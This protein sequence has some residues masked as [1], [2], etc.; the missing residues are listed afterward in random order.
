[1]RYVVF[2][3]GAIGGAIGGRLFESGQPVVL[4]ARGEHQQ[5][6]TERGLELRDPDSTALLK[7]PTVG[8]IAEAE[9]RAGDVVI[10]AVKSQHTGA[11]LDE[12]AASAPQSITLVC[13]QNGVANERAGLRLFSRVYGMRVILAA[14]H[15]EPGVVE[16]STAPVAGIL[17]V[18]RYPGG[19]DETATKL[20][21]DLCVA[22]FDAEAVQDVM[23]HKY[24][25]LLTNLGNAIEAACGADR[26]DDPVAKSLEEEA[27][28]EARRC[29]E[30]AGIT[31]ADAAVE[32]DQRRRRGPP[33]PVLGVTRRGGSS[34]QSLAR[35]TGDIEADWLN[36]E[37]VL[38]GRL[39]GIETPVNARLQHVANTMARSRSVP[40]SVPLSE[41]LA[42]GPRSRS[43]L[44]SR[45]MPGLGAGT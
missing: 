16:I 13:A 27:K 4:V 3:A 12:L 44:R 9:P 18:G 30:A 2:G 43:M 29:F 38:L 25:K 23:A 20:A 15:L 31:L 35:A 42:T 34:H 45:S 8:S 37:I 41:L 5:A 11:A 10:L 6:L 28:A 17:A 39:H 7:I 1:M 21:G 19:T 33:R 40:G 36:G 14:S 26:L 22:R 32:A 24:L